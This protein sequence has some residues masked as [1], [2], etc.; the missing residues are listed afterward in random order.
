MTLRKGTTVLITGASSGI[1]EACARTLAAED[2]RLI[3][4]ARRIDRLKS[5][6][7]VL[8]AEYKTE[9]RLCP[10]DVR[11]PDDVKTAIGRLPPAWRSIDVLINNAGLARGWEKISDGKV[12][13]WDEVIDSNL[14][15]LLYVT[16]AVL[17]G[18]IKR[19]KGHIVNIASISG[20]EAYAND[21]VYIASKA[22]VRALTDAMKKD[23]F[24]TPVRI[25][26]ISPGIV[27]TNFFR[28]RYHGNEKRAARVLEGYD[29]LEPED[30][31][32]AVLFAIS[33][34]PRV[35]INEIVLMPVDQA[36][37]NMVNVRGNN[38]S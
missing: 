17:P 20:I 35:N 24:G 10:F 7:G 5:L 9:V 6:A 15:G 18:M 33:R 4:N 1:G 36:G 2:A 21:A 37:P 11:R 22:A 34:K 25:T 28:V 14:K 12:E 38:F 8:E 32:D 16:R 30:V 13:E 29:P 3:L 26:A 23:L 19:K 27:R 31:S